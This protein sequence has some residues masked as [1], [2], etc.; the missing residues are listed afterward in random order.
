MLL[1][2]DYRVRQRDLLLE[3][4]RA[5]TA[6]LDLGEVLKLVLKASVVMM[7]GQVAGL[8]ALR[9]ST[10]EAFRVRAT[11]NIDSSKLPELEKQVEALVTG[12]HEGLDMEKMKVNLREMATFIDPNLR[13]MFPLPLVI[14]GEP[15]GLLLIFRD[16][17]GS[18]T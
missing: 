13:Q 4:S 12:A 3:I 1:L 7:T 6:Q 14:A 10:N 18:T 11:I 15:V 8:I 16:Y 9:D 17:V 5:M 2:P